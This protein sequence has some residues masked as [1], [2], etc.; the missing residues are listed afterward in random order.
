MQPIRSRER[1]AKE[2]TTTMS[3]E[4]TFGR[5]AEIPLTQMTPEQREGYDALVRVEAAGSPALPGPLKIWVDNPHLSTAVAPLVSYF[6]PPHNS[7][8]PRERE[9]AVCVINS[10][11]RA[12]YS[13]NA[14]AQL[15]TGLG[16]PADTVNALV[17]GQPVSLPDKREQLVYEMVTALAE[18]RWIPRDL[19]ERALEALGHNGIT[20]VTVLMGLYTAV[21]LTLNFYDVPA[22]APGI[23]R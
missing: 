8:S 1:N 14:H 17:C 3:T 11:W 16:L 5:Y 21:S 13:T 12:H 15:A 4:P 22:D 2:G 6:R 10:K 19:Y 7:L 18:C 9:I 23:N 20:D